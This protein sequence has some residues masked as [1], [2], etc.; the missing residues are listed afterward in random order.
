[1]HPQARITIS[2][3]FGAMPIGGH[4]TRTSNHG[5]PVPDSSLHSSNLPATFVAPDVHAIN[6]RHSR[7]RMNSKLASMCYPAAA[8]AIT[9]LLS[10]CLTRQT[11]TENGQVVKENYVVKRPLKD[12][13]EQSQ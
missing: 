9:M 2:S 1:M 6:P 8:V 5:I 3:S 4:R 7:K 12:A 10:A 13:V 11:V